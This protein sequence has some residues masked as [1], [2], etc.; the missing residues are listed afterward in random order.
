MRA[1]MSASPVIYLIKNIVNGKVYVGSALKVNY[2]WNV[3]RSQLALNKHH[4]IKLQRSYNK[5]GVDAFEYIIIQYCEKE[6]LIKSEQFWIDYFDSYKKGYNCT[7]IAGSNIGKK[8]SA[9]FSKKMS[10]L[11]KGNKNRL[12]H[13]FSDETKEKMRQ[14][15][16]GKGKPWSEARRQ[17]KTNKGKPWSEKRRQAYLKSKENGKNI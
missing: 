9:E 15:K 2:R 14:A 3:H 8:H 7:P 6:N 17:A 4:S 13:K 11:K 10:E 1:Y 5:Y 12:G 16:I